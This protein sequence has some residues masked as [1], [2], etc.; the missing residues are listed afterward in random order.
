MFNQSVIQLTKSIWNWISD[1][2]S[3]MSWKIGVEKSSLQSILEQ[4]DFDI[5]WFLTWTW[6]GLGL[7]ELHN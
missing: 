6:I 7:L 3:Q 1:S 4:P 5:L 2:E